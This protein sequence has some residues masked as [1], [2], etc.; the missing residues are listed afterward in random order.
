M[1]TFFLM[2]TVYP[3]VQRRAQAEIDRVVGKDRLT[4]IED[5]KA[6]PFTMAVIKEVLRFAPVVPTGTEHISTRSPVFLPMFKSAG[7]PHRV[8]RDDVYQGFRI[9]KGATVIA[10]IW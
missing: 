9:P 5:Q 2:M 7:L 3:D 1:T 10:N 4:T 6:L 8:T